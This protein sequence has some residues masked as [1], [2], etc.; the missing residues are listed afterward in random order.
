MKIGRNGDLQEWLEDWRQK[1]KS[2]RHISH[3][4]GLYPGNQISLRRT[5][6]LA[7]GC[8]TVLE[9]RG[10]EGNGWSSAWKMGCWARLAEPARAL[11]NFVYAVHN[12]TL[13][14]LF[15]ICSKA[16]QVDGSFGVTAAVAEMLLQSHEGELHFLPALPAAWGEGSVEGLCARGGFVVSLNW[17][18]GIWSRAGI[19]SKLGNVCRLRTDKPVRLETAG[20]RVR[21]LRSTDGRVQFETSPGRTY[22]VS[23]GAGAPVTGDRPR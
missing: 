21:T 15:S 5:P 1:E 7:E 13:P 12:Y 6:A 23:A 8:R 22:I 19:S 9:Q 2:H 14:N 11:E 3:L 17:R 10:L 20:G 4:Y 16:M 18:D